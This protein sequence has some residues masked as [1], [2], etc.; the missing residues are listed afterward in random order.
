MHAQLC[1]DSP[2]VQHAVAQCVEGCVVG[3]RGGE[4]QV[5]ALFERGMPAGLAHKAAEA[6]CKAVGKAKARCVLSPV[7]NW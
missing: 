6:L 2:P 7:P 5:L 1:S 3:I 4:V